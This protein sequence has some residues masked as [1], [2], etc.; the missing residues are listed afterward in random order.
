MTHVIAL[1]AGAQSSQRTFEPIISEL[2]LLQKLSLK[3]GPGT[4]LFRPKNHPFS[5]FLWTKM[6]THIIWVTPR[7]IYMCSEQTLLTI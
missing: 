1:E 7:R 3:E 4:H 2:H 5:S 6:C